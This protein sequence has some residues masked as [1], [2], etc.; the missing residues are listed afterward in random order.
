MLGLVVLFSFMWGAWWGF[1]KV[2]KSSPAG[3]FKN[4]V[5]VLAVKDFFMPAFVN[6]FEKTNH[7]R[8]QITEKQS[9]LEVLREALSRNA[10]Y[11]LILIR[12]YIAKSFIIDNVLTALTD[13]AGRHMVEKMNDISIDYKGMDFDPDNK[14]LV[15]ITWGLNG[16]VINAEKVSLTTELLSEMLTDHVTAVMSSPIEIFNLATKLKPIIKNWVETGQIEE[17]NKDLKELKSFFKKF[18]DDP[19]ELILKNQVEVAQITNGQAASLLAKNAGLRFVLPK[20]RATMW[21]YYLG[22]SR[23]V[24]DIDTAVHVINKLLQAHISEKLVVT[25]EQATVLDSLNASQLPLMQ[26]AQFIRQ[27]PLSRVELFINHEALEP[28]WN[29]AVYEYLQKNK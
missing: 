23:G 20:D 3:H 16:F 4:A 11:D 21:V 12:S 24:R 14:Y 9:D 1:Y 10:D 28:T 13:D 17:L 8:L 22:V 25:S 2:E 6:S 29:S 5:R 27:V 19:R 26:K 18:A 15:P 7:V